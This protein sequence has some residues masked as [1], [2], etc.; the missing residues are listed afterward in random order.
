MT[1]PIASGINSVPK[2]KIAANTEAVYV[3]KRA[4]DCFFLLL[5]YARVGAMVY[6]GT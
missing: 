2:E 3:E 6:S 5:F 4:W 1:T